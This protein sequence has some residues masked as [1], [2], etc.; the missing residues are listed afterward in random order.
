MNL[1]SQLLDRPWNAVGTFGL[2]FYPFIIG[3][4]MLLP[5]ELPLSCVLF[6]FVFKAQAIACVWLGLTHQP[7]FP[8][9]KEQ[10][11]GGYVAL[12]AFSL[13]AGRTHYVD[14]IRRALGTLRRPIDCGEPISYRAAV[15]L[16]V[17]GAAYVIA[18]GI[19]QRLAPWLSVAFFA[20]YLM[21]TCIVGRIRAEMGLPTHE[22][23]RLGP[24]VVFGNV[25]GKRLLGMQNLTSLSL[26]FGF[27]RGIRNVPFPHQ[28]EGLKL[29]S[30]VDGN[31]RG[32]VFAMAG[33]V[34][35]GVACGLW[36]QFHCAFANGFG[37]QW[38]PGYADYLSREAWLQLV[39][40]AD[41]PGGFHSGRV[42]ASAVGFILY[43][44]A[45]ALRTS[46]L[47]LPIH[48]AGFALSTTFF[49]DHMWCPFLIAYIVKALLIRYGGPKA[50]N[51]AALFALGLILGDVGSGCLW[52]LYGVFKHVTVWQFWP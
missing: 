2:A 7:E 28:A 11:F 37:A 15:L 14:V 46:A 41:A 1:Q 21:M 30:R 52:T 23:E 13:Y 34:V 35:V 24:S 39:G 40:W 10:S 42:T 44:S 22:M 17:A 51:E 4:A 20:Q 12:L 43:F 16:F 49:M 8:Y 18:E 48:P 32:L 33:A 3:L 26:F 19:N 36:A 31:A 45:M 25:F 29:I 38:R 50:M 27:T 5:I 47:G 9:M 6:Y